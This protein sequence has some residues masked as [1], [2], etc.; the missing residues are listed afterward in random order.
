[1]EIYVEAEIFLNLHS[2]D[3]QSTPQLLNTV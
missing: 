3:I 1:M 2:T